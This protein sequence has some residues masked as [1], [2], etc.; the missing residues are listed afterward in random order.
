MRAAGLPYPP[1]TGRYEEPVRPQ[2]M[3]NRALLHHDTISRGPTPHSRPRESMNA[4]A[5]SPIASPPML[6]ENFHGRSR[7]RSPRPHH[8]PR[9]TASQP[10]SASSLAMQPQ[11]MQFIEAHRH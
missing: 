2:D 10:P 9:Q 11:D 7:D 3:A 6:V 1:P 8:E 4:V 5:T